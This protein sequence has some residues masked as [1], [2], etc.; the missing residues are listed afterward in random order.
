MPLGNESAISLHVCQ[1]Q[2]IGDLAQVCKSAGSI[3]LTDAA[4][5]HVQNL[6]T[7][8]GIVRAKDIFGIPPH[9]R[10]YSTFLKYHDDFVIRYARA[11][12]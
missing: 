2:L 1:P 5:E 9:F 7:S 4:S 10:P 12:G 8:V 6:D 3:W 11:F